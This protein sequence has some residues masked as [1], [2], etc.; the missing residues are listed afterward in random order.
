LVRPPALQ[1]TTLPFFAGLNSL[2]FISEEM[3]N[4]F[5]LVHSHFSQ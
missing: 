2:G 4:R 3:K 1:Q 5:V